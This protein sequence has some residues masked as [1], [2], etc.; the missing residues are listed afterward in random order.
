MPKEIIKQPLPVESHMEAVNKIWTTVGIVSLYLNL[1]ILLVTQGSHLH[2]PG[3][4]PEGV[5]EAAAIYG[6]WAA[7][8]I[9]LVFLFLT[10]YYARRNSSQRLS[11]RVP[12]AF[13]LSL[14]MGD[15][16]T[17]WYQ[18]FFFFSFVVVPLYC[19]GHFLRKTLNGVVKHGDSTI[20]NNWTTHLFDFYNPLLIFT[21]GN[22][23]R[24]HSDVTFFPF[25][26]PWLTVI[27]FLSMCWMS[28]KLLRPNR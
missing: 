17:L 6:T 14:T 8:S 13:N 12:M 3:P 24:F 22:D 26:Q 27:L 11:S 23:Y 28:L 15:P 1:N 4:V 19:Q 16:L 20:A 18:R 2:L 10:L 25:W 7:G 5:R 21:N 9:F